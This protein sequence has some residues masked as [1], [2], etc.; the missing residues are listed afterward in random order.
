MSKN[1][2][3]KLWR[4][5][6]S[7]AIVSMMFVV[8]CGA[9]TE[10]E[11][12]PAQQPAAPAAS[13]QQAAPAQPAAPSAPSQ[14]AAQQQQQAAPASGS[15]GSAAEPAAS[16][17]QA[18]PAAVPTPTTVAQRAL[19]P[20]SESAM[21]PREAPSFA[22]YWKPPTAFYGEPVYGG[23]LRINYEDPLEHAN[24]W[25]ARSGTTIRYRVPTHD[26]LIQDDPYDPGAPYIP[27]LAYGWTVDDDLQGV[28]FF[29]KD[30]V[31]WHNGEPMTCEDARYSY[32]IMITEEGITGS[33]MKN[34][35]TDVDLSQ[36]Q[37]VDESALKFRFTSPSAVPL[38]SF[39]N[40]AAMIFNKAW[41]LEGGE[42]AMF[43]DVTVGT[44]P[45]TW[46]EG[47]QVGVDEQHFTRNPNYHVEGL[48]YIYNL[49]IFG[50][51]D[52]SAQQA[53]MLAH[54]TDWHWIRNFGQYDQYVKHDQI[55]T[56]IR[57]TRSSEN[58]WINSRNAPFDNVR[59][60]QAVAMGFDKLTGIKVT[61]QGYGSTGLGLMPPGSPWAVTEE[62]ACS[63]PGWCPP[64]DMEAQRAAAIQILKEE[65]FDFDKTY[66]LTVESDNQR[67]NRATYMQEQL[68]LLGIKTDFDVIETI[69]YRK[70]RQAG[71]WGDFMASTG[72]VA[73]VD[74]P[75]LGL[76]HYH[77]CASLY[78]FQT[79]GSEC[80]ASVEAKFEEL[81][82][83]TA[84]EDRKKLG[85]EIQIELMNLYWNFPSFWE[86]EG[87]AFWPEVRGYV[88][89]P[90]PTSSHLRW[91]HMWI[92]PNHYNDSGFAG[93]TQGVPGGE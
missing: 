28:T 85:Q 33:Y 44:G 4:L 63:I 2:K 53:A 22:N 83:M 59:I 64:A 70:S 58:L 86:Q 42:E 25:G 92:D 48:P 47:Q 88:H 15:G 52:E 36:M 72:G 17:Q 9:A 19:A 74:D 87:V 7:G 89:F 39:G 1:R 51:L 57:A 5:F 81:G 54:Q 11:E 12:Q 21:G 6:L 69:A 40:P 38:L 84:F 10:V 37:C 16:S 55:Q 71:D 29:L 61:L 93:Q 91:A 66:V 32:E 30:N 41:F 45:F 50:I 3:W 79:P 49:T 13:Q 65:G 8:A 73:G 62:Q 34:R 18:A 23:T 90:G 20:V 24:V 77:R 43:Q 60:R 31:M 56:V 26:T 27:G 75:F 68:R 46:D 80:N 76:G 78:N 82:Q 14:P 35:L 67:V